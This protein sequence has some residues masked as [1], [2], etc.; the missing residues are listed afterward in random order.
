MVGL[1]WQGFMLG[2]F[3]GEIWR[4][5]KIGEIEFLTVFEVSKTLNLDHDKNF[6]KILIFENL[7]D[8]ELKFD[9]FFEI[10]FFEILNK[11]ITK[12][13]KGFWK[14]KLADANFAEFWNFDIEIVQNFV[15]P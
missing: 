4:I 6:M 7:I 5:L 9:T 10:E 2:G 1:F 13:H 8:S 12:D 11:R 14:I 3:L 15:V